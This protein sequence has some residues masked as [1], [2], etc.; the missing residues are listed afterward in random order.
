MEQRIAADSTSWLGWHRLNLLCGLRIAR[1]KRI[2]MSQVLRE[3]RAFIIWLGFGFLICR[4]CFVMISRKSWYSENFLK[5]LFVFIKLNALCIYFIPSLMVISYL[6]YCFS[7]F[8]KINSNGKWHD[9][10]LAWLMTLLF[11]FFITRVWV[12]YL[13]CWRNISCSMCIEKRMLLSI[14]CFSLFS[15]SY[16]GFSC[17]NSWFCSSNFLASQNMFW[18]IVG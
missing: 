9:W 7:S 2:S 6:Y 11:H 5:I 18:I 12:F 15:F 14:F 17:N 4:T 13:V 16:F 10:L 8:L 3:G 1:G